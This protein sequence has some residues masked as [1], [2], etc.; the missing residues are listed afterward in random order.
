M[1]EKEE[2][3]TATQQE[4]Q[5]DFDRLLTTD[6]HAMEMVGMFRLR[7][8]TYFVFKNSWGKNYGNEG[9]VYLSENYV[10][11]KTIAVFMSCNAYKGVPLN[12]P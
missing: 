11:M 4:R 12:Q 6:D 3:H 10:R 5:H 7:G 9:F 1:T 8:R 2:G